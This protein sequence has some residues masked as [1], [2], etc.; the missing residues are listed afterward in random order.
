MLRLILSGPLNNRLTINTLES[1]FC[2]ISRTSQICDNFKK[3]VRLAITFVVFLYQTVQLNSRS[4]WW[5]PLKTVKFGFSID[6]CFCIDVSKQIWTSDHFCGISFKTLDL[7]IN[8]KR[9]HFCVIFK[10]KFWNFF[11]EFQ[12]KLV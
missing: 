6:D 9:D 11:M 2:R 1:Y 10:T 4:F 7:A 5:N 3:N 12:P 8:L